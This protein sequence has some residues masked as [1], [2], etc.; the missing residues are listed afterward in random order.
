MKVILHV[1]FTSHISQF[2]EK[3]FQATNLVLRINSPVIENLSVVEKAMVSIFKPTRN[4]NNV[5]IFIIPLGVPL[6]YI[7]NIQ[8]LTSISRSEK[9]VN[10]L[11]LR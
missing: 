6:F 7:S 2:K 4:N 9:K 5:H 1:F 8:Y 10:C 11:G 3:F